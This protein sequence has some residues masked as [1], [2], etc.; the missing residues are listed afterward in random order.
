M[1]QNQKKLRAIM[2]RLDKTLIDSLLDSDAPYVWEDKRTVTTTYHSVDTVLASPV[3][4]YFVDGRY[5]PPAIAAE[6]LEF[7]LKKKLQNT[8]TRHSGM[9]DAERKEAMRA[10]IDAFAA[11][12]FTIA[13][14]ERSLKPASTATKSGGKQDREARIA[15]KMHAL[16]LNRIEDDAKRGAV[17]SIPQTVLLAGLREKSED[18]YNK[19][20]AE[21]AAIVDAEI[22]AERAELESKV[23]DALGDIADLL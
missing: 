1:T 17:A 18:G 6:I 11:G 8:Y 21:A 23:T 22:E 16:V 4:A 9:S 20:Y 2:A 7:G 13:E 3:A 12:F 5:I 10:Q 19:L 15:G 14:H